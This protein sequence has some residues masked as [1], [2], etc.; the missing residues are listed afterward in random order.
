M[1]ITLS[2]GLSRQ[3]T[4]FRKVRERRKKVKVM[5]NQIRIFLKKNKKTRALGLRNE[6]LHKET[7][8]L[9]KI[10]KKV[11]ELAEILEFRKGL[12]I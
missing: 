9:K 4:G 2:R 8:A 1:F 5:Q 3:N 7:I 12:I 6:I 11:H 10:Y